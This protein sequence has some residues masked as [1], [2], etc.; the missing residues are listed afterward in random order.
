MSTLELRTEVLRLVNEVDADRIED[1]LSS[2]R[3]FVAEEQGH[4]LQTDTPEIRAALNESLR[5]VSKGE[6]F[7]NKDVIKESREWLSK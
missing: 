7:S 2:I 5:Q 4:D 6:L 3:A 1:L